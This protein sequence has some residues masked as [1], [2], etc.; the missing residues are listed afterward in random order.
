[1]SR[2]TT[3][4]DA[5]FSAVRWCWTAGVSDVAVNFRCERRRYDGT[6]CGDVHPEGSACCG[7][8]DEVHQAGERC[9]RAMI[10][11]CSGYCADRWRRLDRW[12]NCEVCKSGSITNRRLRR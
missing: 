5:G 4:L 10:G 2:I 9:A 6:L 7:I 8:C 3:L 1:M 11:V 12:G